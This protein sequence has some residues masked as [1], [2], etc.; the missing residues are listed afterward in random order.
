MIMEGRCHCGAVHAAFETALD[1][2]VIQVRAC[3]C[4]FCRG[5]GGR[6]VSDPKG[7]LTLSF[8]ERAV[9]R[10]RFASRSADFLLCRTCGAYVGVILSDAAGD[11]GV[12]NVAGMGIEV[13]ALRAP[14]FMDHLENETPED[15]RARRK[16]RWT[17]VTLKIE[18]APA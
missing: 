18:G 7:R 10:Y 1:P 6:T 3:Q 5:R 13:L 16:A 9:T 15:K 17:P 12:V 11:V 2:D 14:D 8:D 4:D